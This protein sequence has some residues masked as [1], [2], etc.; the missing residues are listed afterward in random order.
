M[1]APK[2]GTRL[3][4]S[5]SNQKA[6][7]ANMS[8][9]LIRHGRIE[10]T[11]TKAKTLR[12]HVEKLITKAKKGDLHSRRQVLSVLK[13][14]DVVGYLFEEVGPVFADRDGGYT[15]ILR[16]HVRKGDGTQM[17]IIEL[18]DRPSGRGR[19]SIE[20]QKAQ[21]SRGLFG[22]RRRTAAAETE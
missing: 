1:P 18:V 2:R 12:P 4:G 22:R 15:R 13:D 19:D 17:A 21:R 11:L 6:M 9:E 20:G 5:P 8:A 10:T 7:M 3:G 16:T 14:R